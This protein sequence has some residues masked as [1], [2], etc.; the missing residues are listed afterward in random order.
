VSVSLRAGLVEAGTVMLIVPLFV[1]FVISDVIVSDPVWDP[2]V[3][4]V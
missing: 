4:A 1:P 2:P 3:G